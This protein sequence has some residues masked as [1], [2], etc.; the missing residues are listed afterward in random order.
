MMFAPTSASFLVTE[1][2]NLA[3][4]YC[5]E[6][7]NE[8]NMSEDVAYATL[9]FL[10]DNALKK[11]EREFNAMLFG[12]EPL[13]NVDLIDKIFHKG[14]EIAKNKGLRFTSSIITNATIMNDHIFDILKWHKQSSHLNIQLSIDGNTESQ[15]RYRVTKA[16]GPSFHLVEKNID[17]FK[18]LYKNNPRA[19]CIHSCINKD[20][21]SDMFSN[22]KFFVEDWG[23]Q[24]I[25][26]LPVM[27]EQWTD[28]D[29]EEYDKQQKAIC[30][31]IKRLIK[32]TR[33]VNLIN[34]YAPL[35][36]CF[37]VGK[38]K[39]T[40]GAGDSFITVTADGDIYPCHQIYFNNPDKSEYIGNIFNLN[41]INTKV[42]DK[43]ISCTTDCLDCPENC[44]VNSC[45]RCMAVNFQYNGDITKQVKG[46][47]CDMMRVDKKYQN[48]IKTFVQNLGL[49]NFN[50]ESDNNCLCNSREC[51]DC[52]DCD[53]VNRQEICESGNNPE[54]P[55]CM[56]DIDSGWPNNTQQ[57]NVNSYSSDFEETC[58]LAFQVI[59]QELKDIKQEV[60]EL[61]EQNT[62]PKD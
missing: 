1:N 43:Y 51:S 37:D 45:Y 15:N 57:N 29:V 42:C 50:N 27:E 44:E 24:N 38:P 46:L 2:C 26:F 3:C 28:D 22:F 30:D 9:E 18:E 60:K 25:W 17:K 6:K 48:E 40:C 52:T 55:G 11:N 5:F 39:K 20:T 47:Y 12:G 53:I 49:I 61:R 58:A 21:V 7:H 31:Y 8:K 54:N 59:L 23:I 32:I 41:E 13:L 19:L 62:R 14:E 36:R 56:C 10:S 4:K 34:M 33:D 35:D 16:G